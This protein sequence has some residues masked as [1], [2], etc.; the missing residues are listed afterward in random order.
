MLVGAA[1]PKERRVETKM[2]KTPPSR[3]PPFL[4]RTLQRRLPKLKTTAA[5]YRQIQGT[6]DVVVDLPLQVHWQDRIKQKIASRFH[7]S[8][9]YSCPLDHYLAMTKIDLW[10]HGLREHWRDYS[11]ELAVTPENREVSFCQIAV[12][13][14]ESNN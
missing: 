11:V 10:K 4:P 12:L 5:K 6:T 14:Y 8:P 13:S 1:E 2:T 7:A 3:P 9:P